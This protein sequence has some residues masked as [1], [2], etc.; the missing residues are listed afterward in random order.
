VDG[1]TLSANNGGNRKYEH[2]RSH[3]DS[4]ILCEREVESQRIVGA[5]VVVSWPRVMLV[6]T[7]LCR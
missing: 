1:S 4:N 7:V 5:H 2:N 6:E 3:G